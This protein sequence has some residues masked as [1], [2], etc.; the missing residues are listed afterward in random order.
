M[1]PASLEG[2]AEKLSVLGF[3]VYEAKSYTGLLAGGAQTGYALSKGSGVP[4]PKVYETLRRLVDR[5]AALQIA[6][7]PATFVAV[8]PDQLF[9]DLETDFYHRLDAAKNALEQANFEGAEERPQVV[10]R[11]DGYDGMIARAA[12]MIQQATGKVY[13]SGRERELRRLQRPIESAFDRGVEFIILH[14]GDCP[15]PIRIGAAFRH[16]STD[17]RIFPHHQARHLAIVADSR[18]ALWALAPSGSNW[19]ATHT[20]DYNFMAAIKNYIRHDIYLQ[21]LYQV[22]G[23]EMHDVF[24]PGLE[25]LADLSHQEASAPDGQTTTARRHAESA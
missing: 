23:G 20:D 10:W 25:K 9:S 12:T 8:P 17:G 3:S 16:A 14:F 13:L 21:R 4:Q 15:F 24:G 7:D 22:F 2:V 11:I 18:S 6:D 5:G 1:I 19:S